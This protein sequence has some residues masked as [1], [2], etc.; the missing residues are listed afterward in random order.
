M[1]A[2]GCETSETPLGSVSGQDWC[3]GTPETLWKKLQLQF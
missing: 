1:V 3:C 2:L